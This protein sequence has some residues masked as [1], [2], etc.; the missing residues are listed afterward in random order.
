MIVSEAT[1]KLTKDVI[2]TLEIRD[3]RMS[4]YNVFFF[5]TGLVFN[6]AASTFVYMT[7]QLQLAFPN[8]ED[9]HKT[10]NVTKPTFSTL[11]LDRNMVKEFL[12]L[13]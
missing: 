12:F 13:Y 3:A 10:E 7:V 1:L 9:G 5:D 4:L 6:L 8:L 2:T 11:Q